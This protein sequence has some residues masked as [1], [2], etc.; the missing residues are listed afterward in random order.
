MPSMIDQRDFEKISDPNTKLNILFDYT[1]NV[2]T[3]LCKKDI[4]CENRLMSCNG[5]FK[6]LENRKKL[7]MTVSGV[8]G[9]IGGFISGVAKTVFRF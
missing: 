3:L 8:F 5:R 1:A 4:D 6:T 9:L 7:D 2:Y